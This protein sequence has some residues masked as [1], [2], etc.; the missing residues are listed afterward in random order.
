[1][2]IIYD[3]FEMLSLFTPNGRIWS[4]MCKSNN[5]CKFQS[6]YF[7]QT[8]STNELMRKLV[9]KEL[10]IFKCFQVDLKKIEWSLQWWGKQEAMFYQ[11]LGIVGSQIEAK[12]ILKSNDS[13]IDCTP[14][15]NL[16][17][18]IEKDLNFEEFEGL[19]CT[20]WIC[21]H[22]KCCK[23]KFIFVLHFFKFIINL[24]I[25]VWNNR[26]FYNRH[27]RITFENWLI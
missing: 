15:F 25:N 4:W 2:I 7:K 27:V 8:P 18:M 5:K 23:K 13:R 17:E 3:V 26:T 19:F 9:T 21:G 16:V 6:R 14:P 11:I 24:L 12:N 22:I 20:R 1:M 10:L